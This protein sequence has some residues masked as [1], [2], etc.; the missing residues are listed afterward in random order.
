[1]KRTRRWLASWPEPPASRSA[2]VEV[3]EEAA[4]V[5]ASILGT[6]AEQSGEYDGK[7]GAAEPHASGKMFLIL[8]GGTRV[9]ERVGAETA[10][11]ATWEGTRGHETV[12]SMAMA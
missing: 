1:M 9:E 8:F 7:E 4:D 6:D 12:T 2:D 5:L 3:G 11:A 10:A